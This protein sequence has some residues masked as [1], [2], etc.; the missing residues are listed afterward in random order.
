VVAA[1]WLLRTARRVP[2]AFALAAL[3]PVGRAAAAPRPVRPGAAGRTGPISHARRGSLASRL[4]TLDTI[5]RAMAKLPA[6]RWMPVPFLMLMGLILSGWYSS[7]LGGTEIRLAHVALSA[8]CVLAFVI[9]P[10]SYLFVLDPFPISRRKIFALILLPTL[11]G[12][13]AGYGVGRFWSAQ[14]A[15]HSERIRPTHARSE[16]LFYVPLEFCEIAPDGDPPDTRAPWGESHPVWSARPWVG[17]RAVVFSPFSAPKDASAAF[18][19]YQVSRAVQAI[20]GETIPWREIENRYF[21]TGEDGTVR[22]KPGGL[23]LVRDHPDLRVRGRGPMFPVIMLPVC[24]LAFLSIAASF[25]SFRAGVTP[26]KRRWVFFLL[27]GLL[28]MLHFGIFGLEITDRIEIDIVDAWL[29]IRLAAVA[30]VPGGTAVVW[31]VALVA[32]VL[33]YRW[34]ESR[35]ER[36]EASPTGTDFWFPLANMKVEE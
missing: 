15:K 23:A 13:F 22:I 7:V 3:E 19:A 11:F 33:G 14:D 10:L 20:Y 5:H 26:S 12:L 18:A 27:L 28:M 35:F 16:Y 25:R 8:Y 36:I 29:A 32:L 21:E 6:L 31:A 24:L 2:A 4:R 34:L 9:A 30:Q 17:S 1:F